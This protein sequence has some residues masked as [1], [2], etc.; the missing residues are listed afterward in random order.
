MQR[1]KRVEQY[2]RDLSKQ[3]GKS[4]KLGVTAEMT[5][6]ALHIW[7]NDASRDLNS[8][9]KEGILEKT[10]TYPVRFYLKAEP[11][12][13]SYSANRD[14]DPFVRIIGYNGSLKSQIRTAKAAASYPPCG[15]NTF[16]VGESGVG[17]TMLAEEIWYYVCKLRKDSSVPF[18]AYNC[19]EHTDNPQLLLSHLFG[20]VKGAFTGA[21]KDK[22]GIVELANGGILLLDEIHRLPMTGQEMLFTV[23]D[24]GILSPLGSVQKKQVNLM[25]IGATTEK[26]DSAVLDTFKRRMP[27]LIKIPRLSERP[28]KERLDLVTLFFMEESRK[29]S[30]PIYIEREVIKYLTAFESKTNIGDLKNEVQICCAKGYLRYIE[31][32]EE[33]AAEYISI[34]RKDVSRKIVMEQ[35][36]ESNVEAFISDR[37]HGEYVLI[38]EQ[39]IEMNPEKDRNYG[40]GRIEEEPEKT[41]LMEQSG[42]VSPNIWKLA[43]QIV[44]KAEIELASSYDSGTVNSIALWLEQIRS[45]AHQG[46][47]AENSLSMDVSLDLQ[48]EKERTFII[49]IMSM[50]EEVLGTGLVE[51]EIF[52][53]TV[54]LRQH[55]HNKYEKVGGVSYG[56]ILASEDRDKITTMAKYIN[57]IFNMKIVY[58]VYYSEKE[59][60][61]LEELI[62]VVRKMEAVKGAIILTDDKEF[63]RKRKYIQKQTKVSCYIMTKINRNLVMEMAKTIMVS[64]ASQEVDSIFSSVKWKDSVETFMGMF[65]VKK[66]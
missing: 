12:V 46:G 25:I 65:K 43:Q 15:L 7:R 16:I 54:L 21:D 33:D 11:G 62:S 14:L 22:V 61:T 40:P 64:G 53:L 66:D 8:L 50:I 47:I 6:E 56:F 34:V 9:V 60:E 36:K 18:I 35:S 10:G 59:E 31:Q 32:N 28:L 26:I 45:Y 52:L 24:K 58:P 3:C 41:A 19:A 13:Q 23:M 4:E 44:E 17:K 38:T 30:M 5:A 1:I 55:S 48:N 29:L 20:H 42:L 39:E 57:E 51:D 63:S 2:V 27:I 49:S 37:I